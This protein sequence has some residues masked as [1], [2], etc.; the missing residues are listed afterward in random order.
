M[1]RAVGS[2]VV[3]IVL[4]A[5]AAAAGGTKYSGTVVAIDPQRGV[6]TIEEVGPGTSGKA[7]VTRRTSPG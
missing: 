3:M 1:L 6:M 7:I 4:R 5:P 2:L